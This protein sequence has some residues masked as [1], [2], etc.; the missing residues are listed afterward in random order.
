M[1]LRFLVFNFCSATSTAF[2]PLCS[3]GDEQNLFWFCRLLTWPNTK[4]QTCRSI[5]AAGAAHPFVMKL[6]IFGF[7]LLA[8]CSVRVCV[9]EC[10]CVMEMRQSTELQLD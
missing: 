3:E 1:L 2:V 10:V 5:R 6:Q 8:H 9:C 4:A 7:V